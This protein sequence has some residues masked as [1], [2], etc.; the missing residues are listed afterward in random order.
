MVILMNFLENIIVSKITHVSIVNYK[1][2]EK[3]PMR[4]RPWYGI[5]FSLGGELTYTH[6]SKKFLSLIIK[7]YFFLKMQLMK[8]IVQN[9]V[10]LL[11][12][13]FILQT[14]LISTT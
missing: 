7:L 11:S 10:H 14:N 12:L 9:P 3:T 6:N 5:A 2:H 8:L 1:K 13:T 4:M